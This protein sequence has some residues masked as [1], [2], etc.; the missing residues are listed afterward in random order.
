MLENIKKLT[1]FLLKKAINHVEKANK[2]NDIGGILQPFTYLMDIIFSWEI[3][4][5][6]KCL[7]YIE[8]DDYSKIA[9]L[10]NEGGK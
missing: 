6:N 7:K 4:K 8:T 5:I 3:Q 9:D 1:I 2:I 10:L